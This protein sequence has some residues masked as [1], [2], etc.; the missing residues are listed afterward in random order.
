MPETLLK[1][2]DLKVWFPVRRSLV[3]L[4]ARRPQLY[5]HAV[6][7]VTFDIYRGETLCLVGES[8]CGKTTTARAIV[9]LIDPENVAG[10]R[11][12]LRPSE[13]ILEDIKRFQPESVTEEGYVDVYSLKGKALLEIRRET[14]MIFQDPFASLNPRFKV[15]DILEEPLI[16]HKIGSKEER[17]EIV[18]KVLETVKLTPP[19]E[20]L[21]RYPHQLSGGQRQRVAIAR[22]LVLNP[23]ILAADEP[24]SMLDV[25]IRAEVLEVLNELRDRMRMAILF[26]THDLA[27]ARYVCDRIA[28]M[29]LG[30][31]VE[32]GEADA[33]IQD[34][35]HP[36]TKALINAIPEPEPENRK[37]LRELRIK[38]E[39]TSAVKLPKGC[40]FR[41]RCIAYDENPEIQRYCESEEPGLIEAKKGHY[42]ACWLYKRD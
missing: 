35:L 38:G 31:I 36:Y 10:G 42:A 32:L 15:L 9:R 41:P 22:A 23:K 34:P 1:V 19:E 8:G 26:I 30:K 33:I 12:L 28:V 4:L 2:E 14:Q 13:E 29:Y 40:R 21:S 25:S 5:V 16:V 27:L 11:I 3:D 20:F 37:K 24:V 17:L 39:V 7:G 6:D 18:S